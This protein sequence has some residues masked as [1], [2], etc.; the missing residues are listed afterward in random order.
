MLQA[1]IR[2][3]RGAERKLELGL[4]LL[5]L[6]VFHLVVFHL[7]AL[8]G[9][10]TL[11]A[12]PGH[13]VFISHLVLIGHFILVFHLILAFHLV[14]VFHFVLAFHLVL[15]F[16]FVLSEGWQDRRA[17]EQC[18][19]DEQGAYSFQHVFSS[20]QI[21]VSGCAA[22]PSPQGM[23]AAIV[24]GLHTSRNRARPSSQAGDGQ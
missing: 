10:F 23:R 2:V 19:G 13:L 15:V 18:G 9:L 20:P 11:L 24:N 12:L 3:E 22:K 1:I 5:H 16:H 7:V 17:G 6:V 4:L 21:V 8:F 14:L